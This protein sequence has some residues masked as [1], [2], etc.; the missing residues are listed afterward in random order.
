MRKYLLILIKINIVLL[1]SACAGNTSPKLTPVTETAEASPTQPDAAATDISPTTTPLPSPLPTVE[2][3][4]PAGDLRITV[5]YDNTVYDSRLKAEWGFA[6]LVEYGGHT[7][8]FDTGGDG[9]TLLSN[10]AVLGFD[11]Q[12]I[13][14]VVLS[15]L[16]GDHTGG[17]VDLLEAGVRPTVYV[18]AAFPVSFKN[19]IS[20]HTELVPVSEPREILPGIHTTGPMDS[21]PIA[22]SVAS[23]FIEQ[24]LVVETRE[25]IVVITG[26]AHPG[27]VQMTRQ[28]REIV[29]DE[30]ALVM[31]GFHLLGQEQHSLEGTIAGFHDLGVRQ[32]LP[33]HCTGESAIG[34]FADEYGADYIEGGVG[35]VVAVEN[36][37]S[38]F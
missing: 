38:A 2:M 31:G 27:I 6:A 4:G 17:L 28:A 1:I 3:S 36:G 22:G 35:C 30:V 16:H 34:M 12:T 26:C 25:G 5:V 18:P 15:H 11:P 33:T 23:I 9:L 10:I 14:T 7:L 13:K 8:L 19:E 20:A 37:R 24:G 29:P 21:M 32:V